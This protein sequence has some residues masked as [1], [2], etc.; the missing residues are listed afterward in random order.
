MQHPYRRR[1]AIASLILILATS[2]GQPSGAEE[3]PEDER[4][5]VRQQQDEVDAQLDVLRAS[6]DEIAAE[7]DRL[8]ASVAGAEAELANAQ[9]AVDTAEARVARLDQQ[10][11][12]LDDEM[13]ALQA[14]FNE[15]AIATYIDGGEGDPL[16][17]L[18]ELELNDAAVREALR[19]VARGDMQDL[20]DALGGV[21]AEREQA[22]RDAEVARRDAE[23]A[24]DAASSRLTNLRAAQTQQQ[25]VAADVEARINNAL[26]E[27]DMLQEEDAEL[28][29]EIRER[30]R[31]LAARLPPPPPPQQTPD[32]GGSDNVPTSPPAAPP[33]LP[34]PPGGIVT[35]AGIQV[36]ASIAPQV[37]GL[38]DQAAADG[39]PLGGR[40]YRSIDEQIA[41]R[42][43]NCGSS[44]YAIWQMPPGN[45]SPDTAIP[46]QSK[47]EIGLAI[48]FNWG[49]QRIETH[50][51]PGFQWLAANAPSFG[52][53]N[54]PSEPWHW[55]T[56]GT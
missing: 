15:V 25:S 49:G 26:Y 13:E 23:V 17:G 18:T 48:D 22:R 34:E 29:A 6:E 10:L 11:A 38:M 33:N 51:H 14:D 47:H 53:A 54:L 42:I 32:G 37:Q 28:S 40:G 41:L 56:D 44:Q 35:V 24:R 1:V 36:A 30:Q 16:G 45:C 8:A 4:E 7:L 12:D 27:A 3:D 46:G 21:R 19:D 50:G 39:V 52:F 9:A 20:S 43:Q 2:I 55:S 31:E 5:R